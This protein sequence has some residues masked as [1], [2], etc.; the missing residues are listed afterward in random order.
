MWG[1][2]NRRD[3]Y[4]PPMLKVRVVIGR[5]VRGKEGIRDRPTERQTG[6]SQQAGAVDPQGT[7]VSGFTLCFLPSRLSPVLPHWLDTHQKAREQDRD[8]RTREAGDQ[9]TVEEG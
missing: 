5:K 8:G 6:S 4:C 1:P 9:H 7:H 3:G 2:A